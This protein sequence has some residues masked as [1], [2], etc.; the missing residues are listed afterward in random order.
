MYWKFDNIFRLVP[1]C[2]AVLPGSLAMSRQKMAQLIRFCSRNIPA[3][4][5]R[6]G[7]GVPY[8]PLFISDLLLEYGG[9]KHSGA[10]F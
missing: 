5:L 6:S 4:A 3:M 2:L 10:I 8:D 1:L 9:K 7:N